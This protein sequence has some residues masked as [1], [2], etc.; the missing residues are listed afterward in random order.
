MKSKSSLGGGSLQDAERHLSRAITWNAG[1]CLSWRVPKFGSTELSRSGDSGRE[2]RMHTIR[3]PSSEYLA[4]S[5]AALTGTVFL[6][7]CF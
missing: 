5:L 6:I 7:S 2:K 3:A 4:A 1:V